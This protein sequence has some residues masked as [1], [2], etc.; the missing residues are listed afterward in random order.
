MRVRAKEHE[1]VSRSAGQLYRWNRHI[2]LTKNIINNMYKWLVW[3]KDQDRSFSL[4][5]WDMGDFLVVVV[6]VFVVIRAEVF[7]DFFNHLTFID[8]VIVFKFVIRDIILYINYY[9]VFYDLVT[10]N[11]NLLFFK[12]VCD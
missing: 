6:F 7:L 12:I 3:Y 4:I 2:Y 8:V 5:F 10:F 11:S 1:S 9:H